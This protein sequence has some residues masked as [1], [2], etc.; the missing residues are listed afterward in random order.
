MGWRRDGSGEVGCEGW[1]GVRGKG[2][3]SES[4]GE[5]VEGK[6]GGIRR[7]ELTR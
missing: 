4:V 1:S 2:G 5:G 3:G 6:D 7:Y